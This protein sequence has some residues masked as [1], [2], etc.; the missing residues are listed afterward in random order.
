MSFYTKNLRDDEQIIAIIRKNWITNLPRIFVVFILFLIPFF[1]MFPFFNWGTLGKIV[2][3]ILLA[4]AVFYLLK[5]LTLSYFNCLIITN[6]RL[7]D[8]SQTTS[9]ERLV[10]ETGFENITEVS[11]KIKGVLQMISKSGNLE[12][13]LK[14]SFGKELPIIA[15]GINQPEKIQNLILDLKKL[16]Q[17][18]KELKNKQ[19]NIKETYRETLRKMKK[20]IGKD[21]LERLMKSLDD[22]VDY[23]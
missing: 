9:F 4:I 22:D 18:E 2:F 17:E 7:I 20:D 21:G 6:Q 8:F 23:A 15:K 13:K 3:S 19:E 14:S 16:D 11:Y 5:L 10:K 1:F 12:I